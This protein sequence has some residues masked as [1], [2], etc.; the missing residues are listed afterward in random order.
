MRIPFAPQGYPFV[1]II[2]SITALL[3]YF[4]GRGDDGVV[5]YTAISGVLT[6]FVLNFFRDPCRKIPEGDKVVTSPADG[7]VIKVEKL[8]DDR[9]LNAEVMRVCIFMNVFDVHV[10]RAPIA[11]KVTKMVY[12]EGKFFPADRDKASLE[13]EQNGVFIVIRFM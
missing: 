11:G 3:W 8:H 4:T 2:V 5:V 6:A 1:F 13:N 9:F 7:K 10:N 12:N